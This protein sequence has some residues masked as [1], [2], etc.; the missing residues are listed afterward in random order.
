MDKRNYDEPSDCEFGRCECSEDDKCGC[1]YPNNVCDCTADN[2]CGC[3]DGEECECSDVDNLVCDTIDCNFIRCAAIHSEHGS[4]DFDHCD[5]EEDC[6]CCSVL[7]REP[8]PDFISSAIMPDNS[9]EDNFHMD[10]YLKDSYGLLFFYPADFTFVCPSEILAHNNRIEEFQ[11][12]NVKI[13]GVSVDSKY[14][15][16]AWKKIPVAEGGIGKIAFPLV[17]DLRKEI[18]HEYGVLNDDGVALRAS[19]LIDKDGIVR[20]QIVNDLFLGRDVDETLRV[21]DALQFFEQHG[22][23][24]PAGWH[25]G[26]DG[27]IATPDGVASYLKKN[28]KKL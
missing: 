14:S 22:E 16:L 12:R 9:I 7:V 15:H 28:S 5:C 13:I 19:F 18:S 17:S 2:H 11:K 1:T 25:K 4:H 23:V 10:E 3:F 27:M 26:D 21:I 20:H 8:A 24:C 6:H